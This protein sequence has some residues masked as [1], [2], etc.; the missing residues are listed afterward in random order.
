MILAIC[1]CFNV[2]DW[3][4]KRSADLSGVTMVVVPWLLSSLYAVTDEIHQAFVPE[5]ACAL[6]D[7]GI[8]SAGALFGCLL[9]LV[10]WKNSR[11]AK[12][13]DREV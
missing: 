8:D 4:R 3:M 11:G 12:K 13:Q 1:F 9:V 2:R 6:M 7:V 5:R 10:I